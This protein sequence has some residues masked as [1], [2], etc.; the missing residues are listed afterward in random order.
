MRWLIS[1][2]ENE[3]IDSTGNSFVRDSTAEEIAR[4]HA[5]NGV[6]V[7]KLKQLFH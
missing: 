1:I 4:F 3:E 5:Q 6:T 2:Q 7:N